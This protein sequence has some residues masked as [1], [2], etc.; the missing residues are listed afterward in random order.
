MSDEA[1]RKAVLKFMAGDQL[2]DH[3]SLLVAL[4]QASA[5]SRWRN[6]T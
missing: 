6:Q 2:N 1:I 4:A 5:A 3:E